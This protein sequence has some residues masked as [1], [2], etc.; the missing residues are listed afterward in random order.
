[1]SFSQAWIAECDDCDTTEISY[2]QDFEF[3]KELKSKG[4]G[5]KQHDSKYLD[6]SH[7]CPEC[8]QAREEAK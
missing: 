4:W 7:Y 6:D 3:K 2:E 8:M 1:M 5:F